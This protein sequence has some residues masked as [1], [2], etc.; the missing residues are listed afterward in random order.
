MALVQAIQERLSSI[1]ARLK[2]KDFSRTN[3]TNDELDEDRLDDDGRPWQDQAK[4]LLRR[5]ETVEVT[6]S[7]L[8]NTGIGKTL[9]K[10]VKHGRKQQCKHPNNDDANDEEEKEAL[11]ATARSLIDRWKSSVERGDDEGG[12]PAAAEFSTQSS[13]SSSCSAV[14]RPPPT[15]TDAPQQL[16][17]PTHSFFRPRSKPVPPKPIHSSSS[18]STKAVAAMMTT[19]P[20]F[21][22]RNRAPSSLAADAVIAESKSL[23]RRLPGS[24]CTNPTNPTHNKRKS[25]P[26]TSSISS[27]TT[28]TT[29]A[30]PFLLLDPSSASYQKLRAEQRIAE[31]EARMET[32]RNRERQ[33]RAKREAFL[34]ATTKP[35]QS[36]S[37]AEQEHILLR[38]HSQLLLPLAPRFPVP[39]HAGIKNDSDNNN[40][41]EENRASPSI[42]E[43]RS[44]VLPLDHPFRRNSRSASTPC[45]PSSSLSSSWFSDPSDLDSSDVR[46][47]RFTT[48]QRALWETFTVDPSASDS[49]AGDGDGGNDSCRRLWSEAH[50]MALGTNI[51]GEQPNHVFRQLVDYVD[52]FRVAR[53]EALERTAERHRSLA[54]GRLKKRA[55]RKLHNGT[56]NH[57]YNDDD[58][59]LVGSDSEDEF[60]PLR[61]PLCLLTGPPA[62]GKTAMVHAVA[63]HCGRCT[64][65]EIHTGRARNG[66][67]L[68]HAIEEAT[69]SNSSRDLLLQQQKHKQKQKQK[70]KKPWN[71]NQGLFGVSSRQ[72]VLS[73]TEEE[74]DKEANKSSVTIVLIDEVDILF[75]DATGG[76]GDVGFWSAL[77]ALARATKS[78]IFLTANAC[79]QPL[80]PER[81]GSLAGSCLRLNVERPSPIECASKLLQVGA[82]EGLKVRPEWKARGSE[83]VQKRLSK[84]A[85]LC[86]SDLRKLMNELQVFTAAAAAAATSPASA[87]PNWFQPIQSSGG[88]IGRD[89]SGGDYDKRENITENSERNPTPAR[90]PVVT[91]LTPTKI[92]MDKHS[93]VTLQGTGFESLRNRGQPAGVPPIVRI[94]NH[95]ECPAHIIDDQTLLVRCPP[96]RIAE[97]ERHCHTFCSR[98]AKRILPVTVQGSLATRCVS[99]ENIVDGT[100]VYGTRWL[101]VEYALVE[102]LLPSASPRDEPLESTS[103]SDNY[104]DNNDN[105]DGDG[106]DNVLMEDAPAGDDSIKQLECNGAANRFDVAYGSQS[107]DHV[108]KTVASISLAEDPDDCQWKTAIAKAKA[109]SVASNVISKPPPGTNADD[110]ETAAELDWLSQRAHDASDASLLED[111]GQG[112]PYL[113]GACRGFAFDYTED[114]ILGK[115]STG[116][117]EALRMHEN[118]R[119]PRAEKL[120][121]MGWNDNCYFHGDAETYVTLPTLSE[122][123]RENQQYFLNRFRGD[124]A[125]AGQLACLGMNQAAASTAISPGDLDENFAR[126]DLDR[127][128]HHR[129]EQER[130]SM[131]GASLEEDSFL[132]Y[133]V[134]PLV[135]D[136]PKLLR[137]ASS[138]NGSVQPWFLRNNRFLQSL[139]DSRNKSRQRLLSRVTAYFLPRAGGDLARWSYG[140]FENDGDR[141]HTLLECLPALRHMASSEAA[142]EFAHLKTQ[143]AANA[144]KRTS[145]RTTRMQ[146][147]ATRHHYFDTISVT[148][149]RDEA[150]RNSGEVGAL[151]VGD[152]LVLKQSEE[153]PSF[154][155]ESAN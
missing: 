150:D 96:Y 151:L 95:A 37:N 76:K 41:N 65:L 78:P 80:D 105:G 7:I 89:G 3:K 12:S 72:R 67:A 98:L 34:A 92:P 153:K 64:V 49:R 27:S 104:H 31:L 121:A 110:R 11:L 35:S 2:D 148:L 126:E 97:R 26:P 70:A 116:G 51:A 129:C 58:D 42:G 88:N 134:P 53:S 133:G 38:K 32:E 52:R 21:A 22:P 122:R 19:N 8:H 107:E 55:K 138:T 43:N 60:D 82:R 71:P 20:F 112:L 154:L 57:G 13:S 139:E 17:M 91:S 84:I 39:N 59:W 137:T 135:L 128:A 4:D 10:L 142:A 29:N 136:L 146:A 48:V 131:G 50:G 100:R 130:S 90:V 62:S 124:E 68:K 63:E 69:R 54:K 75:D 140:R 1:V 143:E 85:S 30:E 118:S 149:R 24:S 61:T 73:D 93:V 152:R 119:P 15:G 125:V 109:A 36:Q 111:L 115:S 45:P 106:D 40:D 83:A 102:D 103:K 117:S 23:K 56:N 101:T 132:P 81:S 6:L 113:S 28:T 94:G 9:V 114:C 18:S 147:R 144:K 77:G 33:R 108:S 47:T 123:K 79:P 16:P 141:T 44:A 5:L 14:P 74:E 25:K 120:F 99:T 66:A 87:T 155:W 127:L 86:N 145:R 46:A